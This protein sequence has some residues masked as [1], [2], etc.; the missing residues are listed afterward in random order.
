MSSPPSL[1]L[2]LS[3]LLSPFFPFLHTLTLFLLFCFTSAGGVEEEVE[4]VEEFTGFVLVRGLTTLEG[5]EVV[6]GALV[7]R[8][9]AEVVVGGKV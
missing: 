5:E 7:P 3:L 8:G 2:R 1:L 4:V 6:V 9:A